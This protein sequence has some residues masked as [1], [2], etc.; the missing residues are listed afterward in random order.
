MLTGS[1]IIPGGVANILRSAKIELH[2]RVL[3][4][5][6]L[7]FDESTIKDLIS[8]VSSSSSLEILDLSYSHFHAN[9]A[10]PTLLNNT[11]KSNSLQ[12]LNLSF[13]PTKNP[14]LLAEA[15]KGFISKSQNLTHLNLSACDIHNINDVVKIFEGVKRSKSL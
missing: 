4:L 2:L 15:I 14:A 12:Y 13:N 10:I 7:E 6:Q 5:S 11:K 1:T 8:L 9:D 3:G